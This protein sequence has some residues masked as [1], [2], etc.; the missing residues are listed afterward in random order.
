MKKVMLLAS[1]DMCD[2]LWRVL[3][4]KYR[5]IPCS[6]PSAGGKLLEQLP[7]V[8][9]LDLF[10]PGFNGL[11]FLK[12][13]ADELPPAVVVLTRFLSDPL[14]RELE[15]QG[16]TSMIRMPCHPDHLEQMISEGIQ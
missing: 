1:E 8:L 10:L 7:E 16:I 5:I 14:L 2:I 6:D 13:H 3:N 11:A 15:G 12:D 4:P 9:V